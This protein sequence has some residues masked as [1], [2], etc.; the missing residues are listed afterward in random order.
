M[1]EGVS[2]MNKWAIFAA[3]A[4]SLVLAVNPG[5]GA[6][7]TRDIDE[8][9]NKGV[10]DNEDRKII[11]IF[12][13][14]AVQEL[15]RYRD[16]TLI[17]RV[18]SI[19]LARDSSNK[20]S[21]AAQ[22]AEQ[23]SE[24]SYK[25]ISSGFEQTS[26]LEPEDRKL[27]VII[28]LLI[29]IDGLEDP[30]LANLA[31]EKLND[32]NMVIRYWAVHSITNPGITEQL[33]SGEVADLILAKTIVEQLKE[34]VEGANPEI[35]ALMAQFAAAVNI[36]QGE[37]LLGQIV[38]MR[39]KRYA[40]WTVEYELLDGTILKL[41]YGKISSAGQSNPD[42]ARRFAQLYSYVIQMYV[43]GRDVLGAVEK[44]WLASV[45]VETEDKYISEILVRQLTIKRA[46]ER[47]DYTVLLQ[48]HSRLLG[49]ETRPG[50]LPLKLNF[51]YGNNPD[52]SKRTVPLIL[53]EP[54]NELII[55]N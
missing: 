14:E 52:G 43:K 16:F 19:I 5:S 55:D 23:F 53:Q 33:N 47:G 11:D 30:R 54:P 21:A 7:N 8:V 4:V 39:T 49:D 31:M 40:D 36:P 27:K 35:I 34:L 50:Q 17:S 41:L 25:Y 51:D 37:D 45:L 26:G 24:S 29:L 38:D 13:A 48:E 1:F 12:V 22:Y 44:Q 15:V 10:L 18:R 28:N 32:E 9:R 3:L 6:I 2:K 20:P 42:I 46:V